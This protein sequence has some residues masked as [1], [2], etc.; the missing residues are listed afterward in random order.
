M[1]QGAEKPQTRVNGVLLPVSPGDRPLRRQGA[2]CRGAARSKA[3]RQPRRALPGGDLEKECPSLYC[4][5]GRP[6]AL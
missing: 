6:V 5:L 4:L 1:G 2:V 3:H